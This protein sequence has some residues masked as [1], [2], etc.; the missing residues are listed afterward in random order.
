ML[1]QMTTSMMPPA[2]RLTRAALAA[3]GALGALASAAPALA[4][5]CGNAVHCECGDVIVGHA[6]LER[7]LNG[8]REDGLRLASGTLDCDGHQISGPRSEERRRERV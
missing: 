1:R 7:D 3:L 4:G 8:C 2:A 5:V 6:I